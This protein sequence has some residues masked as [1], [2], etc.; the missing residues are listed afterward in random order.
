[1]P[2]KVAEF[3]KPHEKMGRVHVAARSHV[4]MRYF[5]LEG[6][7]V[8]VVARFVPFRFFSWLR[9]MSCIADTVEGTEGLV[10][11]SSTVVIVVWLHSQRG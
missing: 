9:G 2:E 8:A 6:L 3:R 5:S 4:R 7:A 1:M 10:L 11:A